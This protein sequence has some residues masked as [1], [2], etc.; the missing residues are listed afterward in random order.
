MPPPALAHATAGDVSYPEEWLMD[1]LER[2]EATNTTSIIDLASPSPDPTPLRALTLTTVAGVCVEAD[3]QLL[4][5][6]YY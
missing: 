6:T 1:L 3:Y 2:I 5:T 4:L